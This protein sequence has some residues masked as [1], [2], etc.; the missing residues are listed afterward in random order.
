M[1]KVYRIHRKYL[2]GENWQSW[3]ILDYSPKL[4]TPIFTDDTP[5]MYLAYA[6]T[7]AY[8]PKFSLPI[9][10][11]VHFI[12]H[13]IFPMHSIYHS[14]ALDQGKYCCINLILHT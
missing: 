8:L 12:P 10:L 13:Q 11:P 6:P 5:K 14:D 2:A 7:V 3:R 1:I 4:S 9:A